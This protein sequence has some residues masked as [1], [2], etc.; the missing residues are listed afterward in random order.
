MD[1]KFKK[2]FEL[3]Q[4]D[5]DLHVYAGDDLTMGSV[6]P[7][8]ISSGIPELDLYAGRKGGLPAAK[9]I[10]YFGKPF[11]GKTTAAFHAGAEWQR[12]GG[13]VIFIDT[14]RGWS[15]KR[16]RECGGNPEDVLK[17]ECDTIEEVF[18]AILRYTGEIDLDT[19]KKSKAGR[20]EVFDKDT[21]V[22]F[23]VDSI[24][25][26][27]TMADAQG[28]IDDSDRPGFEA[29]QIKRGIRKV[30]PLLSELECKPSVILITHS[31]SK[32]GGFGKQTDSG[33]G[34]G[35]KFYST[36]RVEFTH[37]GQLKEGD[38][39]AGQKI[40]I[41]VIKL[42]GAAL[43]YP[44]FNVELTNEIGF[45]KYESLKLAMCSTSFASRPAKSHTIT[46][47]PDTRLETQIKQKDFR[48]W[49]E[50]QDGGYDKVYRNW[51]RWC[52]SRGYLDPWGGKDS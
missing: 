33:G 7:Y 39:R 11:C 10:E 15:P 31:I 17:Y 2:L 30:N 37:L 47:L 9:L 32:I 21:P 1:D 13:L 14:E 48:E 40:K 3:A 51:R 29:K 43:E 18:K 34:L 52:T 25:G 45:D 19:K 49:V 22:L 8:G 20:L 5:D 16:F 36:M 6:A 35:P 50:Q 23:I 44:T 46:I 42:R 24:T 4:K 27:P 12:R 38:K 26:A 41:E 28:D